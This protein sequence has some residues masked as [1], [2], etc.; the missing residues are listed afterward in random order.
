MKRKMLLLTLAIPVILSQNV[1]AQTSSRLIAEAH[2]SNNGA[3]FDPVDSS[4]FSY[5]AGRGGDLNHTMKYD[6]STTWSYDTAYH[7]TWYYIQSFDAS[8]N[9]TSRITEFWDGTSWVLYSNTL[10]NYNTANLM[11]SMIQQS[12]NG[13]SWSPVSQDIYSYNIANKLVIDQYQV[14]NS[15]TSAFDPG[16]QKTYYY[17]VPGNKIN[18]TDQAF[19]S[20][21]PVYTNQWAYT[22]SGTNQLLTTTYNT[23]NGSGWSPS[24]LYSNTYDS[25]GNMTNQLF[26]LYDIPSTSWVNSRLHVY[27][28]FTGAHLPTMDVEQHWDA[29]GGGS[30]NNFMQFTNTYNGFNQLTS[31]TGTSWNIVG[32]FEYALGDPKANYY[33]GTY[34]PGATYVKTVTAAGGD[35]NIYPVPTTNVL[36]VDLKW[37]NAQASNIAIYDASGK[38]VSQWSTPS[39]TQYNGTVTLDNLSAGAYFIKITGTQ[40]QIVKQ[41][42]VAH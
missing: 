9:I 5:S 25:S 40:G 39:A 38:V 15:L 27:S 10:Y 28:G 3:T 31:N 6:N 22:Y 34:V 20:G 1:Q 37:D 19:I 24:S 33:Y 29:T 12:W 18:E 23:W 16:S 32:V 17:D 14:W 41:L 2:W 21:V 4:N 26:Q 8:N 35:A 36:H 7:N 13:S 11:T 30:W 42:V